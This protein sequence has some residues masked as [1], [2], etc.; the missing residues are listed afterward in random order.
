MS[1][2]KSLEG[3]VSICRA[4]VEGG[5]QFEASHKPVYSPIKFLVPA[6]SNLIKKVPKQVTKAVLI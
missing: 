1:R 6:S 2:V 5:Y 4:K 3:R